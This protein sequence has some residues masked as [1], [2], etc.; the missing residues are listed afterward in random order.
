MEPEVKCL[1][2]SHKLKKFKVE[3]TWKCRGQ[4]LFKD[5]TECKGNDTRCK[6]LYKCTTCKD[7]NEITYCGPCSNRPANTYYVKTHN[8]KLTLHTLSGWNCDGSGLKDGC[9]AQKNGYRSTGISG[10]PGFGCRNC[11][12]DLCDRCIVWY[13]K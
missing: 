7:G 4:F 8:C 2:H 10:E 9:R 1:T 6:Y 13:N 11:N 3:G 5:N 12:W